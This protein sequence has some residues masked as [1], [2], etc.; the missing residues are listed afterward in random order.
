VGWTL[1]MCGIHD[2]SSAD[3][4]LVLTRLNVIVACSDAVSARVSP[5]IATVL[6][7]KL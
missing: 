5:H 7:L 2:Y 4:S 1:E 6:C 3:D